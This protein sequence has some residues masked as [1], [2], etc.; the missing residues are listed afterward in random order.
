LSYAPTANGR[1]GTNFDYTIGLETLLK[2]VED[3][4]ELAEK[5]LLDTTASW[6]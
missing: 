5:Y 2:P 3:E 6:A 1:V 4:G